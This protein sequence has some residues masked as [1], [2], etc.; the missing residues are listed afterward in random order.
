MSKPVSAFR[1]RQP[2]H[3]A[4]YT[5]DEARQVLQH[6]HASGLTPYAYAK[7][8]GLGSGLLYWWRARLAHG[9]AMQAPATL[10]PVGAQLTFVPLVAAPPIPVADVGGSSGIELLLGDVT[11]RLHRGF[12]DDTLRRA[13]AVVGGGARC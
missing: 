5:A 10:P 8:H 13:L 4:P 11:V 1:P 7:Q 12:C 2:T 9:A 6:A 3:R